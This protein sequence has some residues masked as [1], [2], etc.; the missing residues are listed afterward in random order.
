[1]VIFRLIFIV[2][3]LK[4]KVVILALTSNTVMPRGWASLCSSIMSVLRP[5]P[6]TSILERVCSLESTQYSRWFSRS[7]QGT[8]QETLVRPE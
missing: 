5:P 8:G 3:H 7:D 6:W 1:M 2:P 4:V